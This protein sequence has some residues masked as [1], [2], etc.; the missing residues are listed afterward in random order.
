MKKLT[1]I[2]VICLGICFF[3]AVKGETETDDSSSKTSV[4]T[5]QVQPVYIKAG[6]PLELT[7]I[8]DDGLTVEWLKDRSEVDTSDSG[9]F[10]TQRKEVEGG[11]KIESTLK[12]TNTTAEDEGVYTCQVGSN[13]EQVYNLKVFVFTLNP[14]HGNVKKDKDDA[15]L[16]C[17]I[18]DNTAVMESELIWSRNGVVIQ[19][20]PKRYSISTENNTLTVFR[21]TEGDEG[22][23]VCALNLNNGAHFNATVYL[24]M[25]PQV[26]H[27]QKSKNVI[28]GDPLH[29]ECKA[30]GYPVPSISWLKGDMPLDTSDDRVKLSNYTTEQ[31]VLLINAT[32]RI[33]NLDFPDRA[34]YVCLA[35]DG[36]LTNN[37]TILVRVKDK[38]AALWPFLGICAEV[39][40]LCV[41]IF[42]YE[43]RRAKK[44]ELEEQQEEADHLTN[45]HAHRGNDEIRQR[46]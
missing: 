15:V 6:D 18:G 9:F 46:K 32:L 34:D 8:Q 33:E 11:G 39:T 22:E 29:L 28:Q 2:N 27:F 14:Q 36:G 4:V 23:Y 12:K 43:K 41:I 13:P 35:S 42:I 37:G 30:F 26:H 3:V 21:A 40:I 44:M 24:Y 38:L 16:G 45:S 19:D 7:C 20:T 25:A 5:P 10:T 17:E 31:G 1:I